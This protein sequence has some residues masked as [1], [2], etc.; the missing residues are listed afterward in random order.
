MKP[1]SFRSNEMN[2]II[3]DTP[4][5]RA[6]LVYRVRIHRIFLPTADSLGLEAEL[7]LFSPSLVGQHPSLITDVVGRIQA[8]LNGEPVCFSLDSLDLASCSPFQRE[9]LHVIFAIPY[10]EVRTYR[11][12]AAELGKPGGARAVGN[13]LAR[14]PFPLVVPCHRCIRSDGSLGGFERPHLKEK[15]LGM[16]GYSFH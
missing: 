11:W 9:V 3:F 5:G 2:G 10:G 16:E 13:A 15:L 8:Y 12:V 14:N 4:F 7:A 6:A 1:A